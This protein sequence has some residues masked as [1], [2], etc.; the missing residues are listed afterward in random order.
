MIKFIL[1]RILLVIPV[2]I[3]VSLVAFTIIQL[4]PGDFAS[5]FK[6]NLLNNG[7]S[8]QDFRVYLVAHSMGGLVCRAF[9]Q[10]PN[11]GHPA[12]RSAVDKLF[13]YASPNNGIDLR[14]VRNVPGW[15]ALGEATNFNR[16]RM[17]DYLGLPHATTEV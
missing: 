6:V 11:L 2:L 13:T 4:P 12:A 10:N 8:E 16:E 17:A 7:V 5:T 14:I 1:L 9:L 3:G 15:S